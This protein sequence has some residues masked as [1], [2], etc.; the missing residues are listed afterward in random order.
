MQCIQR[1]E[2]EQSATEF[3][4]D[5]LQNYSGFLK[6]E[7]YEALFSLF[8]SDWSRDRYLKLLGGDFDFALIQYGELLLS[9]GD[10]KVTAIMENTDR[11][12]QQMLQRLCGLLG[13]DGVLGF[14]DDIFV[15]ALEF[16]ATFV[17][18]MTDTLYDGT[19][20]ATA[21]EWQPFAMSQVMD[22]VSHCCRKIQM[23]DH[24]VWN[25]M[26]SAMKVAWTEA[27][28]DVA[29][30][31][32]SVYALKRESLLT[33]FVSMLLQAIPTRDWA[34]I[35]AALFCIGAI[36][37]C[38]GDS[39]EADENLHKVFSSELFQ[40]VRPGPARADI[41]HRLL[42]TSLS[43]IER[44]SDFFERH[45]QYLPA[46]LELLFGVV[47]EDGGIG[48]SSSKSIMT[49]CSSSRSL[50]KDHVEIFLQHFQRIHDLGIDSVA[51]ERIM[52]GVASIIQAI[53]QDDQKLGCLEQLL[54]LL[55]LDAQHCLQLTAQPDSANEPGMK[56]W[57][58]TRLR[59]D[60]LTQDTAPA[61]ASEASLL[62]AER[63]LKLMVSLARGLQSL[64]DGP[65]DLDA[66]ET[67]PVPISNE[68]LLM[69]QNHTMAMINQLHQVFGQ[70][71][72]VTETI[73][74]IFRAGFSETEEGPFVFPPGVVIE[75]LTTKTSSSPRIGPVIAT[76]CSLV[77][78]LGS[79][80]RS[81]IL[82]CLSSLLPWVL[83]ILIAI[84]GKQLPLQRSDFEIFADP[85]Q[86]L[87]R[88]LTWS[89]MAWTLLAALCRDI[90]RLCC[91][92]SRPV[93]SNY[94]SCSLSKCWTGRSHCRKP[95]PAS[96]G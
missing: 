14:T 20:A 93:F 5:L 76:A 18:T 19:M 54:A 16:W 90:Q 79:R 82:A 29:D 24:D 32:Q 33:I 31:L 88:T 42:Q 53:P 13:C 72:E 28:K 47:G 45:Q 43:T 59:V 63:L 4:I 52:T 49:L 48:G 57:L 21:Y 8:E 34:Q 26:D 36:S 10:A 75:F 62:V 69:I 15:Q 64:S 78:S 9:A 23:V 84:S 41:P 3:L 11:G 83:S 94:F 30:F 58:E 70:N 44:Y 56:Q 86:N 51:E 1:D 77:S 67:R 65:I 27:R 7:H 2:L 80:P 81:E 38:V 35:E 66:E 12:A 55:N 87:M 50:L 92:S 60:M 39:E 40:L 46:A 73:C 85:V 61:S 37:D 22:A 68:R 95:A 89:R 91:K 96:S 17:E 6:D 71:G 25:D 74:H